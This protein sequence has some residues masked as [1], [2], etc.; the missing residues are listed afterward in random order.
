MEKDIWDN[1]ISWLSKNMKENTEIH[2]AKLKCFFET[3]FKF[4]QQIQMLF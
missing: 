4:I 2:I 3:L 1:W